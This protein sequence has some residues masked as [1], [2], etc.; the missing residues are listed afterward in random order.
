MVDW[1]L[2]AALENVSIK[3]Y[4]AASVANEFDHV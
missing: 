4:I 2:K 1:E 3:S